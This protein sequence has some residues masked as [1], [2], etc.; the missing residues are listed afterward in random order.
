MIF[1][2]NA[3]KFSRANQARGKQ[4][5][6][7]PSKILACPS[8]NFYL[9]A[10]I[11]KCFFFEITSI[12]VNDKG[13]LIR[14][15]FFFRDHFNIWG[16]MTFRNEDIFLVFFW[17]SS[18]ARRYCPP[19]FHLPP[20]KNCILVTRLNQAIQPAWALYLMFQEF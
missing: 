18:P 16:K 10:S 12:L 6:N 20:Q 5:G 13:F 19:N 14:R 8:N 7:C 15:H 4:G 17:R 1:F 3:R 11:L 2:S 9:N